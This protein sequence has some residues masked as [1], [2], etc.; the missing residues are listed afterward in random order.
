LA[1]SNEIESV[2]KAW[3]GDAVF[4]MLTDGARWFKMLKWETVLV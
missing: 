4:T 2:R 1:S 3:H